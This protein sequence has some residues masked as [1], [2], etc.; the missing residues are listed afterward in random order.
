MTFAGQRECCSTHLWGSQKPR[1]FSTL[2][3]KLVKGLIFCFLSFK[4]QFSS[5]TVSQFL[6]INSRRNLESRMNWDLRL[7]TDCQLTLDNTE[8]FRSTGTVFMGN[9]MGNNKLPDV[10]LG[11]S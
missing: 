1:H 8:S 11:R 2:F 4:A 5:V 7:L 9:I 6:K 10:G 3:W